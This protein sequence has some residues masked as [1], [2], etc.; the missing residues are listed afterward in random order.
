MNS[1]TRPRRARG[2]RRAL[3]TLACC[4]LVLPLAACG[5]NGEGTAD[6]EGG[7]VANQAAVSVEN[8]GETVDFDAAPEQVTTLKPASIA[9]LNALGVLDRVT[10]RA[11]QYPTE[12]YDDATNAKIAEIPSITD[13]LDASGHLQISKEEVVATSPDLVLGFTDTVN[14]QTMGDT[15]GVRMLEEPGFCDALKS[16][17]TWDDVYDEVRLYGKVFDREDKADEVVADLEKRVAELANKASGEG[18]SVAVLYPTVGGGVTYAYGTGS[19]SHPIVESAGLENVYGDS[20]E[21]VFE[22][23]AEDLV[24]RDP[25]VIIALYS[26]GEAGPVVDAI[27]QIKGLENSNAVRENRIMPLLLNFAE[28]PTPLAV[29][30]LEKVDEFLENNQ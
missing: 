23:T 30:G 27:K 5:A 13:K 14:R 19:M 11:G 8:C 22:V 17:V 25:D 9:T 2:S 12:Y 24:A 1:F 4:T 26:E 21:R 10:A 20:S 15:G 3:A 28:P 18:R 29:D 6:G 16:P 7:G